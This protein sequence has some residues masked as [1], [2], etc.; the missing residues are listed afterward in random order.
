[1]LGFSKVPVFLCHPVYYL[2]NL[3][4]FVMLP[5][6]CHQYKTDYIKMMTI[7]HRHSIKLMHHNLTFDKSV[8]LVVKEAMQIICSRHYKNKSSLILIHLDS[9]T[10]SPKIPPLALHTSNGC[11][12][13]STKTDFVQNLTTLYHV[14]V[15]YEM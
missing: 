4:P 10:L 13:I 7:P 14:H 6:V 12:K 9:P 15:V 11:I 5:Q 2:N 1:M 3:T 8:N